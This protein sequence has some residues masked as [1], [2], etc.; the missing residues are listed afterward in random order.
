MERNS[1][2]LERP[3]FLSALFASTND[4]IVVCNAE[5]ELTYVNQK[6]QEFFGGPSG[7]D[8]IQN[9]QEHYDMYYP[10]SKIPIAK[11]D[12]PLYRAFKGEVVKNIE[13]FVCRKGQEP[14]LFVCNAQ[15]IIGQDGTRLGAIVTF[16]DITN[17]R[18]N[19]TMAELNNALARSEKRFRAIFEQS[20]L[21]I[22]LLAKSGH[23]IL[24]NPAYRQ[25]WGVSEE[26]VQNYILK[27]FNLLK[28]KLLEESGQL[29]TIKRAFKGETVGVPE[30]LYD[31]AKVGVYDAR[32][33]WAKGIL[34]PLKND[35]DEV[36]E[37]VVIHQDVTEQHEVNEIQV[38]MAHIKS[39]LIST[40]DYEEIIRKVGS[41]SIPIL[42]DGCAV[43]LLEG[44]CIKRLIIKHF[45]PNIE[46]LIQKMTDEYPPDLQTPQP[47]SRVLTTGKPLLTNKLSN[48]MLKNFC[49]SQEHV[50][51]MVAIGF[52]SHIAVPLKIRGRTIGCLNL[53]NTTERK[54]FDERDLRTA[55]ELGRHLAV[56]I[57]NARLF[58][59]FQSAVRLRDDF[60]SIASHEL[61]TPITSLNLQIE[62]LNDLI[63]NLG[64]D[65]TETQLMKKFL[66]GTNGQL[67]R[68]TRLVEDML[69]ISRISTGKLTL[70]KKKTN[71]SEFTKEIL[72]RFAD[73]L[74]SLQIELK[75][76][77]SKEVSAEIDP[78]RFEQVITNFM[79]NAIRYGNKKPIHVNLEEIEDK[80]ILKVQDFGRGIAPEDQER[81]FKRFERAHTAEDVSGL[82]LGLFIN[83]Q[84]IEEHGGTVR[85]MSEMGKG[86]T[87]IVELPRV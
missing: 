54:R 58:K 75:Y 84:I 66:N 46:K 9:W 87:F 3:E 76:E 24:V 27:D 40:L 77:T 82:G 29:E 48:E 1:S 25:L 32:A 44:D 30:F 57:D 53:Y 22:Q 35:Q 45:D 78:E 19:K 33:R 42:A 6:A 38:F 15:P 49:V 17:L 39:M 72:G 21:S 23:T 67:A 4:G 52:N 56:A 73:Q 51:L 10:D 36:Q 7:A 43:D 86:S 79:T 16:Q 55:M 70:R 81:I 80:L 83:K 74:K 11:E 61:R 14:L 13:I 85:L 63:N 68:L 50:D 60:I 12:I 69:D 2:L 5:G 34:Y 28:D 59:D 65:T 18:L 37:V 8:V 20:P 26:F 47:T 41:A 62:V 64:I 71:L 31:P